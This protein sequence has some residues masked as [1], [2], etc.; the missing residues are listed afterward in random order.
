LHPPSRALLVRAALRVYHRL[1]RPR[2]VRFAGARLWVPR[3]VFVPLGTVSSGLLAGILRGVARGRRILDIGCGSGVLSIT[4][5]LAGGE[6]VCY[7]TSVHALEVARLNARLNG[8]SGRILVTGSPEEAVEMGPYDLVVSNPPY[9]PLDPADELDLLWC[10][11]EGLEALREIGRLARRA[12]PGTLFITTLSSLTP[13]EDGVRALGLACWK[14]AGARWAG[15]D[16]VYAVAGLA[17][18]STSSRCP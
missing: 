11:G 9:L 17:G 18:P 2:I 4:A 15:L 16:W 12:S 1:W 7:D 3:G 10:A 6:A 5:A 8:V 13:L 14:V